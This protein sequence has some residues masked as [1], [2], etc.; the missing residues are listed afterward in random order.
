MILNGQFLSNFRL[1]DSSP[2]FSPS[3]RYTF[4]RNYPGSIHFD[5]QDEEDE[6]GQESNEVPSKYNFVFK[7]KWRELFLS[8]YN[9]NKIQNTWKRCL[10]FNLK[11]K[12]LQ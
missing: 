3:Y 12:I 1:L 5:Q 2:Y 10:S 8:K 11:V 6:L 4:H 7:G 9:G